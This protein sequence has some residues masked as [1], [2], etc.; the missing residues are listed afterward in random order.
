MIY[1]TKPVMCDYGIC[2]LFSDNTEHL[3]VICNSLDNANLIAQ[4]LNTDK[5]HKIWKPK[6]SEAENVNKQEKV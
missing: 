6:E 4:I 3:I 5:D 1:Y 2:E